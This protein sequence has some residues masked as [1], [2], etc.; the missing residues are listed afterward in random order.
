MVCRLRRKLTHITIQREGGDPKCFPEHGES[1][2]LKQQTERA[3][4][5]L[6]TIACHW[7]GAFEAK[8]NRGVQPR[9]RLQLQETHKQG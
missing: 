7:R 8:F 2:D 3:A 6:E 9:A 1:Q 5:P 4:K